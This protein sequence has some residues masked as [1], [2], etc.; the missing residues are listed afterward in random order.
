LIDPGFTREQMLRAIGAREEALG[1]PCDDPASPAFL[2]REQAR[3]HLRAQTRG[4]LLPSLERALTSRFPE[5]PPEELILDLLYPLKRALGNA[6]KRGNQGDPSKSISS[7]AVVTRCGALV[8]V[9]DEGAG[10]DVEGTVASFRAGAGYFDHHG[11]GLACFERARG[12]VAWDDGGRTLRIGFRVAPPA[13]REP[14]GLGLAADARFM[15]FA[16]AD[17]LPRFRK[18]R[19]LLD[20]CEVELPPPRRPSQA[21]EI[22][23]HLAYREAK[24]EA[25]RLRTL[26]G[27]LLPPERAR[28]DYQTAR[29]LRSAA[30]EDAREVRVPRAFEIFKHHPR[31]VLYG[32]A[33]EADLGHQLAA[34][35]PAAARAA[36]AACG[37]ALARWHGSGLDLPEAESLAEA[38]ARQEAALSPLAAPGSGLPPEAAERLA[39]LVP[40]LRERAAE[41]PEGVSLPVHGSFGW[42][43]A[44][45]AGG[46]LYL[47]EFDG[48]RRSHPGL[49]LGGFLADLVLRGAPGAA[50]D[51][52]A[53][54]SARAFL[55]A[56]FGAQAPAWRRHLPLFVSHAL[57]HRLD[58]LAA[59]G[60]VALR[61]GSS[62]I[63]LAAE[64]LTP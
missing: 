58:A 40:R 11:S 53:G 28:R 62:P 1:A 8:S 5:V 54:D 12:P 44:L 42:H 38:W 23:Y 61:T 27:R 10:F 22:R 2:G 26:T 7:E 15:R 9:R 20:G 51:A 48:A 41:L 16:L 33:P 36:L 4:E 6:Y 34:A 63:L 59:G 37:R 56:Y 52:L 24:A 55:D 57:L 29:E 64:A 43:C 3:L 25:P 39:R 32:F 13:Q 45:G 30:F 50:A 47:F 18:R 49:D 31:L 19:E 17:E 46:A 21:P 35:S 60:E 14:A